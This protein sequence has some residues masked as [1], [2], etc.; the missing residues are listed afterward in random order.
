[1]HRSRLLNLSRRYGAAIVALGAALLLAPS[2]AAPQAAA[3]GKSGD[4]LIIATN[5]AG[6]LF[7]VIGSGFARLLQRELDVRI[8]PRPYGTP[9]RYLPLVE[10]GEIPLALNSAL[11]I[12]RAARGLAPFREAATDLRVI[13]RVVPMLNGYLV[14]ASSDLRR[15][16]DVR[17]KRFV[18]QLRGSA[19]QTPLNDVALATAGLTVSDIEPLA[20]A[21]VVQSIDALIEG[22]V[23]VAVSAL[24]IAATQR[25][26]ASIPG[27]I[28]ALEL[29]ALGD[30]AF[31]AAHMPGTRVAIANP[32]PNMAGVERPMRVIAYDGY[33]DTSRHSD[34]ALIYRVTR[35]L[36]RNWQ[37]LQQDYPALRAL[38]ADALVTADSPVPY[39]PGAIRYYREVGL[40]PAQ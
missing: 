15:L 14:R 27:G 23:D 17:G 21:H 26:Q 28:R 5:A 3:N 9:S 31:L 13:A 39:H 29:G 6:T 19:S 35:T 8:A 7:Y 1:M 32:G 4:T 20:V 37:A 12:A 34:E 40:W 10:H 16:E 25:A 11:D 18:Y 2:P 24:G 33:L 36:H 30:D 22:R 38:P